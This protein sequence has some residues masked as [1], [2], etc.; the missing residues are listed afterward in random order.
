MKERATEKQPKVMQGRR[1]AEGCNT[2]AWG[3]SGGA[4]NRDGAARTRSA[5]ATDTREM[6]EL[7][8]G[9]T[10]SQQ[11]N[12]STRNTTPKAVFPQTQRVAR[13]ATA[14]QVCDFTDQGGTAR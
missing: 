2:I 10:N 8:D 12:R 14:T 3:S 1:T 4:G 9:F 5:E 11:P 13:K 6:V 7:Q